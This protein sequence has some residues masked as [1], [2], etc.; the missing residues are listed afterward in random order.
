MGR[1]VK[2]T[3]VNYTLFFRKL[4]SRELTDSINTFLG[5]KS[6]E[7][8][9]AVPLQYCFARYGQGLQH[10]WGIDLLLSAEG[11]ILETLFCPNH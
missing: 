3:K 6:Q 1:L 7:D 10:I 2:G 4:H 8:K 9:R 5:A 11:Q